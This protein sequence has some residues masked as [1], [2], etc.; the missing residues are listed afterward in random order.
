MTNKRAGN[1]KLFNDIA[2]LPTNKRKRII[3]ILKYQKLECPPALA[4]TQFV[5]LRIKFQFDYVQTNV[6]KP[7]HTP[8]VIHQ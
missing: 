3:Q 8:M 5:Q 4:L 6:I 7:K 1:K 2:N